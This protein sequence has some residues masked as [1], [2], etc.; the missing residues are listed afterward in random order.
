MKKLISIIFVLL[1]L[2]S[3]TSCRQDADF[4]D[5]SNFD[6]NLGLEVL[7]DNDGT[8]NSS[9]ELSFNLFPSYAFEKLNTHFKI[10]S[11][12]NGDI[13][14]NGTPLSFNKVYSF[15]NLTN[16]LVYIG[17]IKGDHRVSI[18]VYNDFGVRKEY[19]LTLNYNE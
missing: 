1:C 13:A 9:T 5:K 7:S 14:L 19:S 8:V 17:K 2:I 12:K 15:E 6:F 4:D 3:V 18:V 11:S 16:E 10:A